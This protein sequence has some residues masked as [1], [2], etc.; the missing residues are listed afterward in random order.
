MSLGSTSQRK[1]SSR[2]RWRAGP[3]RSG[4][5]PAGPS[6]TG[7]V[8]PEEPPPR[9][10]RGRTG[11]SL[12]AREGPGPGRSRPAVGPPRLPRGLPQ[13]GVGCPV[14][15][16]GHGGDDPP[17]L[18][19]VPHAVAPDVRSIDEGDVAP[20]SATH[21]VIPQAVRSVEDVV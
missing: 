9:L 2:P 13:F 18:L 14:L 12:R 5:E 4:S 15:L 19:A 21:G 20:R 17:H 7:S 16:G 3:C 6:S 10:R 1:I 11:S 8:P